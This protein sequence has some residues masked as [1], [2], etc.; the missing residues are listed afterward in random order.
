MPLSL[1]NFSSGYE[2]RDSHHANVGVSLS[3]TSMWTARVV[4]H[5]NKQYQNLIVVPGA[6]IVNFIFLELVLRSS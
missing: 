1:E 4:K 2:L 3:T 6:K 5:V